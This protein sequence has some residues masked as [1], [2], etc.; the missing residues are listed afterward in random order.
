MSTNQPEQAENETIGTKCRNCGKD[1]KSWTSLLCK[2]C[3]FK[4]PVQATTP[5]STNQEERERFHL[6]PIPM[7]FRSGGFPQLPNVEHV[8][9]FH[10]SA[11]DR[12]LGH[13]RSI[14]AEN[15][16]LREEWER[17]REGL[18][19]YVETCPNRKHDPKHCE[20]RTAKEVID[21]LKFSPSQK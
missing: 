1:T 9:L 19:Y 13:I 8:S 18:E 4:P 10:E 12:L 2:D 21:S 3:A 5:M 15:K 6:K 16:L 7:I 11:I 17:M 20:C 14:E